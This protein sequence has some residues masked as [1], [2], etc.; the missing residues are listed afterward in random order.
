M[1]I[2]RGKLCVQATSACRPALAHR[3]RGRS[4]DHAQAQPNCET[5]LH[6]RAMAV[7]KRVL[8]GDV[9]KAATRVIANKAIHTF[10]FHEM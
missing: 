2:M 5:V 8:A 9:C 6:P 10:E 1:K 4:R 3:A 7:F